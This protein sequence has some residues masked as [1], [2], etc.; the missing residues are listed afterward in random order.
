MGF[1]Y[2]LLPSAMA[3]FAVAATTVVYDL[4]A[5]MQCHRRDV[6]GAVAVSK[7]IGLRWRTGLAMVALAWTFLGSM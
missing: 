2:L 4:R 3:I 5:G 1:Q 7:P 6:I